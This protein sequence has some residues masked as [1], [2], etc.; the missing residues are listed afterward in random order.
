MPLYPIR[1][2]IKHLMVLRLHVVRGK[3]RRS[4]KPTLQ[5]VFFTSSALKQLSRFKPFHRDSCLTSRL[6]P[7]R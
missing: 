1:L 5:C 4:L 3:C 7:R 6:F 2:Q